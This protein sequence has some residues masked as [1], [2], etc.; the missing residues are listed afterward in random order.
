MTSSNSVDKK[1]LLQWIIILILPLSLQLIP[2]T[3][4]LTLQIKLFL[5]ITLM[6][7][8]IFAFESLNQ[9]VIALLLPVAY[10]VFEIAPANV[11]FSAWSTSTPWMYV[12]GLILAM[13]LQ[14][15]GLLKRI[16]Y[17]CI[18]ICGASYSGILYGLA[19][20]GIFLNLIIPSQAIIPMAALSYGIC[21]ALDLGKS[22]EAAGIM[23]TAALGAILPTLFLFN[24]NYVIIV[25]TAIEA[26]G[27][28]AMSWMGYLI[29]NCISVLFLFIC[30][31]VYTKMFKP[32][33]QLDNKEYFMA[34]Y[35]AMGNMS[36][37]EKISHCLPYSVFAASY[38]KNSWR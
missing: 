32:T 24:G 30:V 9:T 36:K 23:L 33:K 34:E 29:N 5:T 22:K 27:I 25:N 31:F 21:I 2:E 20:A 4:T 1:K 16:A 18:I 3:A 15:I 37:A 6:A 13:V 19:I 14:R 8:L 26:T 10:I 11:V 35:R 28:E 17:K 12:G 7:I 38:L